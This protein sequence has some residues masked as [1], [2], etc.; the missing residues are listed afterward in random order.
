MYTL[1]STAVRVPLQTQLHRYLLIALI[2]IYTFKST[3]A[4]VP[5]PC[6]DPNVYFYKPGFTS[7]FLAAKLCHDMS[8]FHGEAQPGNLGHLQTVT[9]EGRNH[10][11]QHLM[12][13]AS[14]CDSGHKTRKATWSSRLIPS[15]S[16][17]V[18][19]LSS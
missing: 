11:L 8:S 5:V 13:R 10:W 9:K 18:C 16:K 7:T 1:T 4:Q 3:A 17:P 19:A 14:F 6:S 2:K 15:P 12:F